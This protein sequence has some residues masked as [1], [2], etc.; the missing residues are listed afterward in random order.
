MRFALERASTKREGAE[1]GGGG[2]LTKC[3]IYSTQHSAPRH[4]TR[5]SLVSPQQTF[6]SFS[7][8]EEQKS[9]GFSMKLYNVTKRY[10][11]FVSQERKI[12]SFIFWTAFLKIV[13]SSAAP[14]PQPPSGL[15]V[16]ALCDSCSPAQLRVQW[17]ALPKSDG[18]TA[19]EIN[20]SGEEFDTDLRSAN[21]SGNVNFTALVHLEEFVVYDVRIRAYSQGGP[22]PFSP[23]R[24]ART[25]AAPSRKPTVVSIENVNVTSCQTSC[26]RVTWSNPAQ[27]DVNGLYYATQILWRAVNPSYITCF[28][29][30]GVTFATVRNETD[31]AATIC[32]LKSY[33]HYSFFVRLLTKDLPV[34][35]TPEVV[36]GKTVYG[37]RDDGTILT[38]ENKPSGAPQNV[39]VS[40]VPGRKELFVKWRELRCFETNGKLNRYVVYFTAN[41]STVKSLDVSPESTSVTLSYLESFTQ[42]SVWVQAFTGRGG[43]PFTSVVQAMTSRV[44]GCFSAGSVN[45]TCSDVT[46]Q[47]PCRKGVE[48][49]N[50]D[51]CTLSGKRFSDISECF[52][53]TPSVTTAAPTT[54]TASARSAKPGLVTTAVQTTAMPATVEPTKKE[55]ATVPN[56]PDIVVD[57]KNSTWIRV[58]WSV[59]PNGVLTSVE[60][61]ISSGKEVVKNTSNVTGVFEFG[62][63]VPYRIYTIRVRAYSD[64]GAS[65][66]GLTNVSTCEAAPL[67]APM[68]HRCQPLRTDSSDDERR[69]IRLNFSGIRTR[70]EWPDVETAARH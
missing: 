35:S 57:A 58:K 32:I 59:I 31:T 68:I 3:G 65:G 4:F 7:E 43:G 27:Q 48:G 23:Y 64:V 13:G 10:F 41:N 28:G 18:I 44:C 22:S 8:T 40:A 70:A 15:I 33:W 61:S 34:P 55:P 54:A 46:G 36:Y 51:I 52:G 62:G 11:S 45:Q 2:Y 37:D 42:Y 9:S 20:Y 5:H 6:L 38:S 63:L 1:A 69:E 26:V 16:T 67:T 17:E 39:T 24:S 66:I 12:L 47:C 30:D 56:E 14:A 53:T 60:A 50:C 19:Y 49:R 25:Y 29:D 21:A